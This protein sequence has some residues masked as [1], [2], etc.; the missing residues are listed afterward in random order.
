[1]P[2]S[3]N[4]RAMGEIASFAP[5]ATGVPGAE[6]IAAYKRDGVV[7]LRGAFGR[8]W[9]DVIESGIEQAMALHGPSSDKVTPEGD[10]GYFYYDSMM[11][12]EVEPFRRFIFES[13]AADLFW[14]F[15]ESAS[16]NFYYDFLLVK[17]ARCA[18]AAT[19]WHQD[20]SYYPLNGAKII[21]CW[22]ALDP[23]PPET[24]LRFVRGS[25][26]EGTVHRVTPFNPGV[27]YANTMT[28]R[29]PPPDFDADPD[30]DMVSCAMAPGDPLV[31][32]SRTFHSAP[33]NR[34]D[35][36]RAAFSTNW[37]GDDVTYN[38]M[39]QTSDPSQR[40]ENLVHGGPITCESFPLVRG[41]A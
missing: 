27:E 15:L 18:G 38:D 3:N 4:D 2:A 21:N 33:G 40:G 22:T 26:A 31:W 1:M 19:P 11:W 35:R 5:P 23:I 29:P 10:E 6:A 37:T 13:H 12:K 32:N 16:L 17:S 30:T 24:A 25:H 36:R 20:H 41:A 14:P 34:L 39:P 9:L 28:D 8:D 7:C